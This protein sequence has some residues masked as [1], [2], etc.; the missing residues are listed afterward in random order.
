MSVLLLLT[1]SS[2]LPWVKCSSLPDLVFSS[3]QEA[4]PTS[5]PPAP[6]ALQNWTFT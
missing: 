5:D 1:S 4:P 6:G 2:G 3:V